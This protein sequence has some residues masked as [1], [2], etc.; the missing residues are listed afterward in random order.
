MTE[1]KRPPAFRILILLY[2]ANKN[3][4]LPRAD[5]DPDLHYWCHAFDIAEKLAI[6]FGKTRNTLAGLKL[7]GMANL[8]TSD[9]SWG[10]R[11]GPTFDFLNEGP[12]EFTQSML[13]EGLGVSQPTASR[14]MRLLAELG[15]IEI[16]R[17]ES[18]AGTG[19][20]RLWFK[21]A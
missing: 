8:N 9:Y 21:R 14:K 13:R 6:D 4:R 3:S 17:A 18:V 7:L 15:L 19:G 5:R 16:S 2:D 12:G 1:E 10:F 20:R 11:G